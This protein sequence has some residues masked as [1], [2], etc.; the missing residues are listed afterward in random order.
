[1]FL[2]K[3]VAQLF[4]VFVVFTLFH[5]G[6][7]TYRYVQH[8][9]VLIAQ[10]I[11]YQQSVSG[12]TSTILIIGDST[13]VG[14]GSSRPEDSTAGLIGS[15][16][17]Q[18]NIINEG[19]VGER[20]H[21]LVSKFDPSSIK[22]TISLIVIQIGANDVTH[23]TSLKS[24]SK[25]LTTLIEKSKLVSAKVV[26]LHGGDVGIAPVI[27]WYIKRIFRHNTLEIRKIFLSVTHSENVHYVDIMFD[28]ADDM[29][30]SNPST[31]FA[32]DGF[33]PS[34]AGYKVWFGK[35]KEAISR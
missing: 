4:L 6:Y 8:S 29:F 12:A 7:K 1:M 25:D 30:R 13:A 22:G 24:I 14:T 2:I 16:Y 33:H 34:S 3:I 9:K 31:Y 17:P 10:S 18:S 20:L 26:V 35:I 21:E 5:D 11:P 27:P 19:M 23:F 15:L 32:A 28:G